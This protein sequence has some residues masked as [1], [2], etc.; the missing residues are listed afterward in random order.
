MENASKALIMAGGILIG[1]LIASLFAYEMMSVAAS[2]RE[3]QK[4]MD[5]KNIT[6]FNAQFSKYEGKQLTAQE[7]ATMF[8]YITEWNKDNISTVI[9]L[10]I[11]GIPTLNDVKMG[12]ATIEEFLD[13][14]WDEDNNRKFRVIIDGHDND[15]M[16]NEVTFKLWN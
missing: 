3:H 12:R 9:K 1:L 7:V 2:G 10:N 13:N 14:S 6:E 4:Q 8:N 16:V 15:G 11:I 5:I